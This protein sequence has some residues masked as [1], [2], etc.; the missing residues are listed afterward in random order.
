MIQRKGRRRASG[1]PVRWA[2]REVSAPRPRRLIDTIYLVASR[3]IA[4]GA[5]RGPTVRR[6]PMDWFRWPR[7]LLLALLAMLVSLDAAQAQ[8]S[9]DLP[10]FT[11]LY[12]TVNPRGGGFKGRS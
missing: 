6:C 3:P 11:A 5:T 8:L 2:K 12:R 7:V 10:N 4:P 1:Q 9:T